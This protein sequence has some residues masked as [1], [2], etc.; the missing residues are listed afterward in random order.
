[1]RRAA[2]SAAVLWLLAFGAGTAQAQAPAQVS[3]TPAGTPT[4]PERSYRFTLPERRDLRAE[5]IRVTENAD[6]VSKLSLVSA[7]GARTGEFGAILVIDAS[8][9]MRGRAIRGAIGAAR[10]LARQRSG[11]Q[12]LGIVVFNRT[13]KVLLAPTADEG[14][15][16]A[17]LRAPPPL[18]PQT[19]MFDAV[20]TALDL[21]DQ[22]NITTGS[23]IVLSD[24]SD[25]GSGVPAAAVARRARKAGVTIHTVGLRSQ[26]FDSGELKDLAAAGRGRYI[27]AASV[28]DLRR[29]FRDLGTQLASDYVL[30][31]RSAADPGREVTVAVG[32]A[33]IDGV[34]TATYT[35]PGGATFVQVKDSFWTSAQ[36]IALTGLLCAML[37]A[38]AMWILLV[39][40]GRGPGLR[41]RV[42]GFVSMPGEGAPAG[43]AVLTEHAPGG[44][45]RSLERTEWW[46]AFKLDVEIARISVDPL[47]IVTLTALATLVVMYLLVQVTGIAL[48]GCFAFAIPWAVRTWVRIRRDRQRTLFTDQLPDVLQGAASAIRAGHGFVAALAMVAEDAPEPSRAELLRVVADEALGVPLD[49]ALRVVQERM[50]SRDVMQIALVAQIQRE[51][52]G[53]IAEVLDRITEALRQRSELRRMVKALTAQGR[54]SRWVVTALPLVLLLIISLFDPEYVEPLFVT[55]LGLIMLTL[56]GVMMISGSLVIGKIVNFKV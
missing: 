2:L 34:A 13:P 40:R 28:A 52:G 6:P 17:A 16:E 21:L 44:A 18:A 25:T 4:F 35:V 53:N 38:L 46:A 10:V 32:V 36:G 31:Y 11:A 12:Q 7:G 30:R 37:I 39:R 47:R 48:V 19:R 43:D 22:S 54:L 1:M 27:A 9:S 51:A 15:I 42:R 41:E 33:G 14:A 56:A 55:P 20:N 26:Y 49:E 8:A 23:V 5:D 45:E 24:G 29:I 3:L 50:D